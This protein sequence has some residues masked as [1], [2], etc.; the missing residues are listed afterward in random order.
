[1]PVPSL[2]QLEDDVMYVNAESSPPSQPYFWLRPNLSSRI[3]ECKL[4]ARSVV[5]LSLCVFQSDD[6]SLNHSTI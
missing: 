1:M 2:V 3:R 4:I 5:S 6:W